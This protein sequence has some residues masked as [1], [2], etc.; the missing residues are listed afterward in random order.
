[1]N[2]TDQCFTKA[3]REIMRLIAAT[4][5]PPG[6]FL[7]GGGA[8]AIER[9]EIYLSK[10][11]P[12]GTRL[13]KSLIWAVEMGALPGY[14]R[15]FRKLKADKRLEYL[16]G[17][18]DNNFLTKN[19]LRAL[20]TVIKISHFDDGAIFE[21][22][23][24][25][26]T[27]EPIEEKPPRWMA[28]VVDGGTLERDETVEAEVVV[29]G[30]GAG[31]AVVARELA[32]KGHAVVMLEEGQ[33]YTRKDFTD[34]RTEQVEKMYR[35]K[36][37]IFTMGN[38]PILLPLGR[39]V[40]GTTTINSGTCFRIPDWILEKWQ[41]EF[42]LSMLT[43]AELEPYYRRVEQTIQVEE[44]R[45]EV[46]GGMAR[47]LA[48]GSDKLGYRHGP[49]KRNA[50]EC[51]AKGY[52]CFGCPTDAKRS[53][54]VSYVPDALKRGAM[55]Y[56][57]AKAE[58]ILLENG[59]ATGIQARCKQADGSSRRLTIKAK[60]VIAACGTL[61]TPL[62]LKQSGI[63]RKN[64]VLGGNLSIHPASSVFA[65]F[66]ERIEAWNGI[67]QGY[68]VEEFHR[69][70]I[71]IEGA[72]APMD[73]VTLAIPMIGPRFT[74][75]IEAYGN[76]ANFGFMI[77]DSS[78]GRVHTSVKGQLIITYNLNRQDVRLMHQAVIRLAEI[79]LAAGARK[80]FPL[81]QG[82]EELET[83][84]DLARLRNAHI[85]AHHLDISA[86]HPLGTARMGL[87]P[88]DSV[89]N[90]NHEVHET[91]NLF[92][93]DGSVVPSSVAVNPQVAIMTL[94][95]R[96]AEFIDHRIHSLPA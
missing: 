73:Y 18:K 20:T 48:R 72:Y 39:C 17:M 32:A 21:A 80:I 68:A 47:V 44:A 42:G 33:Y 1:M 10:Q 85:K 65:L 69:Q 88:S 36:G 2:K 56:T 67:P 82:F 87:K 12:A 16:K 24:C 93:C 5:I 96:A 38:T 64:R 22:I 8:P 55:L 74:E 94:A 77:S 81:V 13:L 37:L 50:P 43:E 53:T 95:T 14:R 58:R 23:G 35:S 9:L 76:M 27:P 26:F 63:G 86:F 84:A 28:Q 75:M 54:N 25:E 71:L 34:N 7:P 89:V 79:Y 57:G 90:T 29:V 19:M 62:L 51:E 6:N 45:P 66:D 78:R 61:H 41:K 60:V 59:R 11:P 70:G 4:V 91:A 15:P 3:E 83:E 40:G 52:C 30:T 46:L 49:L 92:I 31:G